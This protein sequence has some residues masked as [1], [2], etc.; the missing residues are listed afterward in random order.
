MTTIRKELLDNGLQLTFTDE[1]NRYFGDYHRICVVAAIVC[2]LQE[3]PVD[4]AEDQDLYTRA[5]DAFGDQL[6]VTKSFER[7]G[8]AS[9]DV[10]MVRTSMIDDFLRS[11]SSY[12]ARPAYPRSM[13]AAE[14][15]KRRT[16]R[17]YV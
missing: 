15:K 5:V 6:T 16:Q 4:S 3:L 12:L 9:A 14:L 1:S 10:E 8:V 7:M 13:V 17:F 11:A 2:N